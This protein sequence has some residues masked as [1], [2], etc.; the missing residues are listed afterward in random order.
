MSIS[1]DFL[2]FYRKLLSTTTV[3]YVVNDRQDEKNNE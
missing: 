2:L 1:S 3:L